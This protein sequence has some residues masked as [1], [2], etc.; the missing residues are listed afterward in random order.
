MKYIIGGGSSYKYTS[1][2]DM[3]FRQLQR[4]DWGCF[5]QPGTASAAASNWGEDGDII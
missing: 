4:R 5:F 2:F 3:N 1:F